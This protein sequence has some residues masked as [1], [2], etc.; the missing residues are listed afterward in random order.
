MPTHRVE[1]PNL[2]MRYCAVII[3]Q[4]CLL[5]LYPLY[6]GLSD[7]TAHLCY[8]ETHDSP[9]NIMF[10]LL[11]F[12]LICHYGI[13]RLL[14]ARQAYLKQPPAISMY[15]LFPSKDPELSTMG[16][17]CPV[18]RGRQS[19]G[20]VLPDCCTNVLHWH[21]LKQGSWCCKTMSGVSSKDCICSFWLIYCSLAQSSVGTVDWW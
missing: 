4:K 9:S 12:V 18:C 19:E 3:Q 6:G 20:W 8:S 16:Q 17:I 10:S 11:A 5:S 21:P 14:Y 1:P 15:P 13:W 2:S 7:E